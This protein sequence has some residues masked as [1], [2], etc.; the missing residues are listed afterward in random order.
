MGLGCLD[1]LLGLRIK[2]RGGKG[3]RG[4]AVSQGARVSRMRMVA[5][6]N[7]GMGGSCT[8]LEGRIPL[9]VRDAVPVSHQC[10]AQR[11]HLVGGGYCQPEG[12]RGQGSPAEGDAQGGPTISPQSG[13]TSSEARAHPVGE[14]RSWAGLREA[15]VLRRRRQ[16]RGSRGGS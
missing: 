11:E 9:Q 14:A 7:P 5:R 8:G 12:I 15:T 6:V 16:E 1:L 4:E 3:R 13:H 10:L 2:S